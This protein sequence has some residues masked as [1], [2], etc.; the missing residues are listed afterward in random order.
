MTETKQQTAV[1]ENQISMDEWR[2]LSQEMLS[3]ADLLGAVLRSN[4]LT[5]KLPDYG[6]ES[7]EVVEPIL[8]ASQRAE[9]K[10]MLMSTLRAAHEHIVGPE[11]TTPLK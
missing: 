8:D 4:R 2:A 6:Q 9:I 10:E 1:E 7:H 3:F 5:V 11:M